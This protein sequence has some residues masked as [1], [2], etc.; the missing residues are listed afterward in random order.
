MSGLADARASQAKLKRMPTR[1]HRRHATSE[2][3][4]AL[5]A[6]AT[7]APA[8]SSAETWTV[9]DACYESMLARACAKGSRES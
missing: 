8:A 7:T 2:P 3:L 4:V 6:C 1:I 9:F 5:T